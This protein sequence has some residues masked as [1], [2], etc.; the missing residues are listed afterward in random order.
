MCHAI[1]KLKQF[2]YICHGIH[3]CIM[4]IPVN[5]LMNCYKY[6]NVHTCLRL[7]HVQTRMYSDRFQVAIS[8][9]WQDN[10][11]PASVQPVQVGRIESR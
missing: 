9:A 10:L 11:N 3:I 7:Y 6:A 5:E 8:R 1:Y 4:Y 2:L